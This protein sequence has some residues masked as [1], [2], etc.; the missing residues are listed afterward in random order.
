MVDDCSQGGYVVVIVLYESIPIRVFAVEEISRVL[1]PEHEA[2]DGHECVSSWTVYSVVGRNVDHRAVFE[3]FSS[4]SELM[5]MTADGDWRL[6]ID[7][8]TLTTIAQ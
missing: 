6:D 1:A 4:V 2:I 5:A 7:R 8:E 3:G